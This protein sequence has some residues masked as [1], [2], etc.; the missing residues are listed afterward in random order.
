[1]L[2]YLKSSTP[3]G[4]RPSAR[5]KRL[6]FLYRTTVFGGSE[7]VILNL[8][9]AIDYETT[10]VFL[11][12]PLDVFSK[13]LGDLHLPITILPLTTRFNGKFLGTFISWLRY[14]VPLRPDKIILAEGGFRDFPF[15]TSLASFLVARGNF[16]MMQLHPPPER[17]KPNS[18]TRL[19]FISR[20]ELRERL[21]AWLTRNTLAVSQGVKDRLVRCYGYAPEQIGIVYNGIDTKHFTPVLQH[22][23]RAL[24][25]D[26]QI[27]ED[28]V[29]VVSTARL[30]EIKRLDRLIQAFAS[31]S[32][33]HSGL[34]LLLTGDGPLCDHL[35]HLAQGVNNHE[36]IRFLGFVEDIC[37]VLRASDIY[38]LPSDEEG[39]GLALAEAMACELVCVATKTVGPSEIIEDGV[40]GFLTDLTYDGVLKGLDRALMLGI[41]ERRAMGHRARHRIVDNF[42]VEE[43]VAK[44]LA[45]MKIDPASARYGT[46]AVTGSR[47]TS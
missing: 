6:L 5:K 29:V 12:S 1:M 22:T 41:E 46:M 43:A 16:W 39:F 23:R 3:F 26:M 17:T 24:R 11:A 13:I 9:K 45:F 25:K 44:A 4:S 15:S 19:G 31:L 30:A 20:A 7:I 14:L 37:P 18:R 36:N 42:R 47:C 10:T 28:A 27:P 40:N 8:L 35:K 21:W 32:L 34:W 38:V 33:Q 2:A